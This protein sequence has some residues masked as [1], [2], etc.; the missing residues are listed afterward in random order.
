MCAESTLLSVIAVT[1]AL[2]GVAPGS[3]SPGDQT[4]VVESGGMQRSYLVHV[5]PNYDAR[6]PTPV[7]LARISAMRSPA[8]S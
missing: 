3:L 1:L 8:L 7:V 6:T 4:R 2:P 5:P